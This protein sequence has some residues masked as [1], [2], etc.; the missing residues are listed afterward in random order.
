LEPTHRPRRQ[1]V[2]LFAQRRAWF[3]PLFLAVNLLVFFGWQVA[4]G[5]PGER[6]FVEN[7]LMS[8]ANVVEGRLWTLLTSAFSHLQSWHFLL[9]M[10]V[11]FSFGS[12]IERL[13]GSLRFV[14]F[15]LV[16]A[17][18]AA[19]AH[20]ASTAFLIGQDIPGL[21]AS[22][23]LA[24]LL[25]IFAL[26]FPKEKVLLFMIIPIPAI[27]VL[28]GLAVFDLVGLMRQAETGMAFIGHG[29][30]LGGAAT[31]VAY[32]LAWVRR[33]HVRWREPDP[34]FGPF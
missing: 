25:A 33:R 20:V 4:V 28:A 6:L 11:L 1:R 31:G 5:G 23:A 21:G 12:V 13:L 7:F 26:V 8:R 29:A 9:N 2:V 34:E 14:V 27:W 32:Y 22:G 17:V 15:Y 18:V 19:L 10:V 3:V 30:H 16:S 24:G